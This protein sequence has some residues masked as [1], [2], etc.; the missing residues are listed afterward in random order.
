[1]KKIT[2]RNAIYMFKNLRK[3][4]NLR[5]A[6]CTCLSYK[7]FLWKISIKP[8]LHHIYNVNCKLRV[9]YSTS[10]T[11]YKQYIYIIM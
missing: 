11:K 5:V 3:I 7:S 1:M 4:T 9:F 10:V 6:I 2:K 8:W